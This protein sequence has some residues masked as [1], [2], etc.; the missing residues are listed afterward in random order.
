MCGWL[1]S[2]VRVVLIFV[3]FSWLIV[4]ML[5]CLKILRVVSVVW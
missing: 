1:V 5:F 2:G 3:V 4:R